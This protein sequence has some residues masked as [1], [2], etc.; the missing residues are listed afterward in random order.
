MST[1]KKTHWR[2][3]IENP[4][5]AGDDLFDE[6]G[7]LPDIVATIKEVAKELVMDPNSK[8]EEQCMILHFRE[9][10]IKPMLVNVTNAKAISKVIGSKYIEDW[11]GKQIQ[12]GTEKVKAFGEIWDALRVKPYQPRVAP[13]PTQQA[14]AAPTCA[15]CKQVILD[16]PGAPARNIAAATNQK[17]GRPLCFDCSQK[18]K[19]A[20]ESAPAQIGLDGASHAIE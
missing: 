2:E 3:I 17:Y 5:L 10:H 9:S 12:I 19:A 15:D 1:G 7:K 11:V 16:Q 6:N 18:V 8:K 13:T 4:Y 14:P 20:M